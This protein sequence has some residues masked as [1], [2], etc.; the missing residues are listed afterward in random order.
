MTESRATKPAATGGKS[1]KSNAARGARARRSAALS[2]G[3]LEAAIAASGAAVLR[4]RIGAK[5]LDFVSGANGL[6]P[7]LGIAKA[8]ASVEAFHRFLTP[9]ARR[10]RDGLVENGARM[11][12]YQIEYQMID[13]AGARRWV[14]ESGAAVALEDGGCELRALI[15]SIDDRKAR[16][17]DLERCAFADE[18]TGAM[19]RQKLREALEVE[20]AAAAREERAAAYVVVG[21]DDLG[22]IN[23]DYGFDIADGV[24]CE[25]ADRIR[26]LLGENDKI[27]RTAGNKF[28]LILFSAPGA[29]LRDYCR[30]IISTV[31][32][33]AIETS[34]GALPVSACVGAAP[35]DGGVRNSETVMARAEAA[36]D[37]AKNVGR[38]SWS[39]FSEKTDVIPSR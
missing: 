31:R 21:I 35:F 13:A 14:E 22:A 7:R 3:E 37:E 15:R 2:A 19:N 11:G 1:G 16:E 18:L 20:L 27:G 30:D 33:T 26:S 17:F 4:Q 32:K 12:A 28:G 38:S 23:S 25:V 39:V 9:E 36:L 29:A 10:I 24:I 34:K 6:F 5:R 8:P